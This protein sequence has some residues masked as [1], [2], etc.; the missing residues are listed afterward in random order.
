MYS[1]L[2]MKS[3]RKSIFIFEYKG[4]DKFQT[5]FIIINKNLI[6]NTIIS[7]IKSK[8]FVKSFI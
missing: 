5:L 8:I 1:N 4:S 7:K 3:L 6:S 2:S